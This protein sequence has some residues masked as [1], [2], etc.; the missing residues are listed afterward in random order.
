MFY[1][2]IC[3]V[4]FKDFFKQGILLIVILDILF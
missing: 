4:N 2:G 3:E 1:I